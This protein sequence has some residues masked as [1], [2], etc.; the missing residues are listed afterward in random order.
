MKKVSIRRARPDDVVKLVQLLRRAAKEQGDDIW[1]STISI[2]ENKQMFHVL[3]L[4][5]R[6]FVVLAE[7]KEQKQIV[8]AMGMTIARDE[9]SDD[10]VM[11]NDWTYVLTTWRDTD[12][13]AQLLSAVEAFA[14]DS[15]DPKS[16]K[17]LPI[18]MGMMTGR[19]TDLKDKLMSRRGYQYGGGNFVRA[20]KNVV[21]EK[22]TDEAHPALVGGGESAGS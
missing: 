4:I 22:E 18:I 17:G 14:D 21:Q 3:T 10:W 13:H 6:G 12:V 16:G 20:P 8:A 1:Y 5:D 9:W 15:G 7:T 11:S 19:D 2:N